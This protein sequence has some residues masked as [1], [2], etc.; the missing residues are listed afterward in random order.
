MY[1]AFRYV[2][3]VNEI[4]FYLFG[5]SIADLTIEHIDVKICNTANGSRLFY[6]AEVGK[7]IIP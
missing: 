2:N 3:G 4:V 6:M 7:K 5:Q 1:R